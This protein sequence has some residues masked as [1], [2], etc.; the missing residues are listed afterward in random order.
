MAPLMFAIYGLA[1]IIMGGWIFLWMI[2]I[3]ALI[4]AKFRLHKKVNLL[5]RETPYPGV[6]VL[7]PLVGIDPNLFSNLETF[8]TMNYPLFELLFCIHDESDP[9]IML[10]KRLMEKYPHVDAKMFVGG[11]QVGVNPKINNM[12][13]G[14]DQAK[15]DLILV[16][17]SGLR[18]KEDT[19]LDMVNHM[20]ENVGLVHQMPFVCDRKGFAATIEKIYFGTTHARIY[21]VADFLRINC[22]TGMSALMRKNLLDDAGGFKA[23]GQYLAEDFFFAKSMRDRGWSIRICSQPAWQ[24]SGLCDISSF[25]ARI[26]RWVK[27]RFAMVP[28]WTV[29]EPFHECMFMGALTSCSAAILF[30]WDPLVFYLVHILMWFLL[31]WILLGIVQNGPIPFSKF[32]FIIGWMLRESCALFFFCKALF[33]PT[34]R[35]RTGTYKLKWGGEVE[36][37]KSKL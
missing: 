2:H 26:G 20:T 25:Q 23:F 21:L 10:I 15:Y 37:M 12:Q 3:T 6:S 29:L 14:Y 30:Q 34:I 16:S 18:M 11:T 5:P 24:N 19:L 9:C 33:D 35:W 7:K 27:L 22:A 4:Y 17:D 13:P 28:H 32:E 8:F 36:I 31:D 1:I